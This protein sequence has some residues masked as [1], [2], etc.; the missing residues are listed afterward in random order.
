[1][2]AGHGGDSRVPVVPAG[3][4]AEAFQAPT[5]TDDVYAF[6]ALIVEMVTGD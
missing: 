5:A 4:S 1:M 2:S 6:G 3:K